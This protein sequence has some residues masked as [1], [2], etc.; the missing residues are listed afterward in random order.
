ME[1]RTL[2]SRFV[3]GIK[4]L[5]EQDVSLQNHFRFAKSR[6]ECAMFKKTKRIQKKNIRVKQKFNY[7]KKELLHSYLVLGIKFGFNKMFFLELFLFCKTQN[8]K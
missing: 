3:H 5:Y 1:V 2:L 7:S 8:K 6:V 4:F